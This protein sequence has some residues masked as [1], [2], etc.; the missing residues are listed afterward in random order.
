[1]SMNT[2]RQLNSNPLIVS[3]AFQSDE[4]FLK[5]RNLLI[6]TY[7]I[8]PV[9]FNWDIRRWDGW[10]FYNKDIT[11]K[12]A[13]TEQVHLWET[14][15]GR[16]VG[17]AHPDGPG[18][19]QLEIHPDFR[20]YIEEEM[21]SWCENHLAAAGKDGG[22]RRLTM[23]VFEYDSPRRR[24]LAAHGFEKT[25]DYCVSRRMRLGSRPLPEPTLAS[26]YLLRTTQPGDMR[27]C[28][29]I[30]DI[31]NASFK[32]TFHNA[33]EFFNFSTC[34]PSFNHELD[35]VAEAQDGTFAAYVGITY[36]PTN[37]CGIF[38]PVCTHP[39]HLRLGLARSL[40]FEGL[41]R[42]KSLGAS[43]VY[44]GTGDMIPANALYEAVGF[45][46][47]YAGYDWVKVMQV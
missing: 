1:M 5:V 10:R 12:H 33:E 13:W 25:D 34:S 21:L 40:M 23:T 36:D 22:A 2:A 19:A 24:L 27:D 46:E 42:L 3:R 39:R 28:Q 45:T 43:D 30:A 37:R 35:L 29:G 26:G 4:D 15:D 9:D 14:P 38:E 44:V 17:A 32:R 8:I 31:L 7:P 20:P 18:S 11:F 41:H 6:E 16:L 47:A